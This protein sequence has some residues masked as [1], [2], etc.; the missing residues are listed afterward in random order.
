[1]GK[2]NGVMGQGPEW[3]EIADARS[4]QGEMLAALLYTKSLAHFC[5][6]STFTSMSL[7]FLL[8]TRL[9]VSMLK[10]S[11]PQGLVFYTNS[12]ERLTSIITIYWIGAHLFEPKTLCKME[13]YLYE[14]EWQVSFPA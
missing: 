14:T 12:P 4:K 10:D 1:M 5:P 11:P 7:I 2:P 13:E 3:L 8:A 6:L 9:P